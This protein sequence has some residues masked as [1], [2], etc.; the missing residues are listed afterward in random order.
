LLD[1]GDLFGQVACGPRCHWV[2]RFAYVAENG[3]ID[4]YTMNPTTGILRNIQSVQR[5]TLVL[6]GPRP[7]TQ[8][9][10]SLLCSDGFFFGCWL[11][12]RYQWLADSPSWLSFS[13]EPGPDMHRFHAVRQIRLHRELS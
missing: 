1:G 2:G 9:Q 6:I 13:D 7:F 4:A 10:V 8:Q 5:Q 11:A 3:Q 12:D